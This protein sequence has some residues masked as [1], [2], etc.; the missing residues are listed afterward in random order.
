MVSNQDRPQ[1]FLDLEALPSALEAVP[2]ATKIE[3]LT[4]VM[5]TVA[6]KLNFFGFYD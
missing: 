6:S 1:H 3:K 4:A 2:E 5:S